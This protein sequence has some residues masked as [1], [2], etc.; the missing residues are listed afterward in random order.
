MTPAVLRWWELRRG[1]RIAHFDYGT[2][3]VEGA[4]PQLIYITWDN[5][6]E[7][8][9]HHTSEIVRHLQLLARPEGPTT[10]VVY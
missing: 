5:P 10:S 2:G 4:G 9:H 7:E 6:D 8:L 3:T 1:D